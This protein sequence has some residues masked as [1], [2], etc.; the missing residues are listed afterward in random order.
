MT[1]LQW[2]GDGMAPKVAHCKGSTIRIGRNPEL[3]CVVPDAISKGVS[4]HHA[5]IEVG[6]GGATVTD[7]GSSN[8]TFVNASE[9]QIPTQAV[10]PL[11]AGD[12]LHFGR[13]GPMLTVLALDAAAAPPALSGRTP[14]LVAGVAIVALGLGLALWLIFGGSKPKEEEDE[15]RLAQRTTASNPEKPRVNVPITTGPVEKPP[16][17]KPPEPTKETPPTVPTKPP[18]A[19]PQRPELVP[20]ADVREVGRYVT[21]PKRLPGVLLQR[22]GE[23]YPWTVLRAVSTDQRGDPVLSECEVLSLPGYH[24]TVALADD[25]IQMELLGHLPDFTPGP[26]VREAC[27]ILHQPA[28]GWHA[29]VSLVVGRIA[30][31]NRRPKQ[32]A[33]IHVRLP[34][35]DW[36][37]TLGNDEAQVVLESFTM[38]S[39]VTKTPGPVRVSY[40][41]SRGDVKLKAGQRQFTMPPIGHFAW[42]EAGAKNGDPVKVDKWPDWLTKPVD[43][44]VEITAQA[45][46]HLSQWE[47]AIHKTGNDVVDT[48]R[49]KMS[50][51]DADTDFPGFR[52]LGLY[53]LAALD[54]EVLT[55][56]FL[57]DRGDPRVRAT[58]ADVLNAWLQRNPRNENT[59]AESFKADGVAEPKIKEMLRLLKGFSEDQ[60]KKPENVTYLL[61][62]LDHDNLEIRQLALWQLLRVA[63]A[64]AREIRYDPSETNKDK[65]ADGIKAWRDAMKST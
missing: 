33:T 3:E 27:V 23:G 60:L 34:R 32:P 1:T 53:F 2:R 44:K 8:G 43:P 31:F 4:W 12:V 22:R 28:K 52:Q 20:E 5:T 62:C 7:V 18:D 51:K 24:N 19:A 14:L 30:L 47:K 40:L 45:L 48:I 11:K 15:P 36:D 65:R 59:L 35:E 50:E 39:S 26:P 37:V 41:F 64:K 25:A 21:T 17:V 13:S 29:D 38:P 46:F 61:D 55:R 63:P 6:R 57:E 58:A 9:T 42:A 10:V 56:R 54:Q 16:P 49:T